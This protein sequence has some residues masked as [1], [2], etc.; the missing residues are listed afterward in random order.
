MS[1]FEKKKTRKNTSNTN[2]LSSTSLQK[3]PKK[4][5]DDDLEEI[6]DKV[7]LSINNAELQKSLDMWMRRNLEESKIQ[8]RDLYILKSLITEYLDSYILF[9]YDTNNQRIIVQNCENPK[10]RDALMEFLKIIF[11]KQQNENFLDQDGE[12]F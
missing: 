3:K 1:E 2:S 4:A 5:K 7:F 9:G 12:D 6:R 8:S 10:D 11:I